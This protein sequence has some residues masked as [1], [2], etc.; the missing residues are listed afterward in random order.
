VRVLRIDDLKNLGNGLL[1][2]NTVRINEW[3]EIQR[4]QRSET[5][6]KEEREGEGISGEDFGGKKQME[7]LIFETGNRGILFRGRENGA[8]SHHKMLCPK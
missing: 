3:F 8:F 4:E 6:N 2:A 7:M 1:G 5:E